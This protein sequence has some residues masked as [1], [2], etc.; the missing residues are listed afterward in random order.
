MISD[1]KEKLKELLKI[2]F[3]Y[4]SFLP[5]QEKAIDSILKVSLVLDFIIFKRVSLSNILFCTG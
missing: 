5:G 1:K 2:H 3:G 4:G